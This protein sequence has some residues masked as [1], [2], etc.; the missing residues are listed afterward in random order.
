[1]RI[2]SVVTVKKGI[3]DDLKS[4]GIFEEQLSDDVIKQAEKHFTD[5]ALSFDADEDNIEDYIEDGYFE[6]EN[7]S[8]NLVWS[9]I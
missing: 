5:V 4:F 8:V 3:V 7:Y 1:M 9:G 2:I 6:G